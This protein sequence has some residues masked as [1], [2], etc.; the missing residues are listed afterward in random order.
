[1]IE[2]VT[3][4]SEQRKVREF[5]KNLLSLSAENVGMW[6]VAGFFEF[7]CF[8]M[9]AV[10]YQE[11]LEEGPLMVIPMM[12][13]SFA[14]YFYLCPYLTFREGAKSVSIYERIKYLP[15]DYREIQK[16]RSIYLA[17]FVLKTFPAML[18]VQLLTTL[19]SYEIT[20]ANILYAVGVSLLLPL[21]INLPVAWFSK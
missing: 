1:M 5:Y 13:G 21:L 20:M 2:R 7:I 4:N 18:V 15:V 9:M 19:F 3:M 16:M 12:F 8:V 14:A 10:P 17:K 6:F 11:M